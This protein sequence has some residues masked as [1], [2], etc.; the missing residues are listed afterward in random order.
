MTLSDKT[1]L[2]KLIPVRDFIYL[3]VILGITLIAVIS[4]FLGDSSRAGENLNFAATA[5]SV[6]LAVIAII[7]TIVDSA[8]QKQ[9]VFDLKKAIEVMQ[10]TLTEEKKIVEDFKDQLAAVEQ[11]KMELMNEVK[12]FITFRDEIKEIINK[13]N[14]NGESSNIQAIAEIKQKMDDY[15]MKKITDTAKGSLKIEI[16]EEDY[17]LRKI[18][19]RAFVSYLG[20]NGVRVGSFFTARNTNIAEIILKFDFD[21]KWIK[22]LIAEYPNSLIRYISFIKYT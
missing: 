14:E 22:D 2:P 17:D 1:H 8:G 21:P 4:Y 7:M 18:E 10:E 3:C 20:E 6:V 19:A 9:N 5:I 15:D 13:E 12:N 11:N 16:D